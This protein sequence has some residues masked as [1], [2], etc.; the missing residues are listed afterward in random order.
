MMRNEKR[1]V[2][3]PFGA[4]QGHAQWRETTAREHQRRQLQIG[5]D[6]YPRGALHF[7]RAALP[8]AACRAH[9]TASAVSCFWRPSSA[10]LARTASPRWIRTGVN[11][12]RPLL[13]CG[14]GDGDESN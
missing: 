4:L 5:V 10:S 2:S 13:V 6:H 1:N 11:T 12:I 7:L 3:D 14:S 9:A 8:V